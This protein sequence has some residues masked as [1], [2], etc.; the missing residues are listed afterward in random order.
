M[1]PTTR[2]VITYIAAVA[3]VEKHNEIA[4]TQYNTAVTFSDFPVCLWIES[5]T[6][7]PGDRVRITIT[8][9]PDDALPSA[10]PL[11]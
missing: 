10:T 2:E 3:S 4:N 6:L 1:E 9:E 11:K 5:T 7:S 8:K